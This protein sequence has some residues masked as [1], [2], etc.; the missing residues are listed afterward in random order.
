MLAW[1]AVKFKVACFDVRVVAAADLAGGFLVAGVDVGAFRPRVLE[2]AAVLR[3]RVLVAGFAAGFRF[4]EKK[5][6]CE[7]ESPSSWM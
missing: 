3:V 6:A 7:S 5:R 2:D 4:S 1:L